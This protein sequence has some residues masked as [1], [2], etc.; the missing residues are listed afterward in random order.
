MTQRMRQVLWDRNSYNQLSQYI[1]SNCK[2]HG[3]KLPEALELR[4]GRSGR[5]KGHGAGY[6]D[7]PLGT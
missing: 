7:T 4:T 1:G 2:G 3:Y 6:Q 5:A